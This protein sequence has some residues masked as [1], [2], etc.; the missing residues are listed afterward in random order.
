MLKFYYLNWING[1]FRLL[2]LLVSIFSLQACSSN[3]TAVRPLVDEFGPPEN[4][5]VPFYTL[6]RSWTPVMLPS[7]KLQIT[8]EVS[9]EIKYFAH[10]DPRYIHKAMERRQKYFSTIATI[11]IDEG[12]PIELL[13]LA[14]IESGFDCDARSPSGAVGMWQF[15]KSTAEIYGL[16]VGWFR[17]D[18]KD[19]ILS[20][21]AA[22][23]HLRDLYQSYSDWYLALAAYNAGPG[24]VD[25]AIVRAGVA[26]FWEISRRG[27]LR[28]ETRRY[29]P[30]FIAVSLITREPDA[31]GFD[32]KSYRPRR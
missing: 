11:F 24:A 29:V 27:L 14:M 9:K 7:P 19:P 25:R 17:D 5:E 22:A 12:I 20:T 3:L 15:I 8:P 21:I 13:N 23:R 30:R 28:R 18:R 4:L 31:H 2:F 10:K 16:R 1:I 32:S 6:L 26:D